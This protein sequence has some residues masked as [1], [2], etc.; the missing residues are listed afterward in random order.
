MWM[1]LPPFQNQVAE[2]V[3]RNELEISAKNRLIDLT[4]EVGELAKEL[5]KNTE[6]GNH[7][8]NPTQAWMDELGDVFFA[9]ISLANSTDVNL[10]EA[11]NSALAKYRSRLENQGDVGSGL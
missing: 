7:D 10:L 4:S 11:L 1:L 9:L 8:F 2:F 6:Y 3:L 5:L